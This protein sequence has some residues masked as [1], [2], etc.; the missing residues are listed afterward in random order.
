MRNIN[1][2]NL[3]WVT[4][5]R[6]IRAEDRPEDPLSAFRVVQFCNI[7][8]IQFFFV[9][10]F[11]FCSTMLDCFFLKSGFYSTRFLYRFL[12]ARGF[13]YE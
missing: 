4:S 9:M 13:L 10:L 12:I 3:R 5:N 6:C 8:V 11:L 2:R 7:I 1:R